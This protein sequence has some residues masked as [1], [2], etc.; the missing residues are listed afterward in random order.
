MVVV[1]EEEGG[2]G[3]WRW[4]LSKTN[5]EA[6]QWQV[7]RHRVDSRF[8]SVSALLLLSAH[9]LLFLRGLSSSCRMLRALPL[10]SRRALVCGAL[11]PL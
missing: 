9:A 3:R 2:G 6:K 10:L 5:R 11:E 7:T 4:H 8:L 1:M